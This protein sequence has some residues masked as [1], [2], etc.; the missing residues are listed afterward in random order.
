MRPH[1]TECPIGQCGKATG[2]KPYCPKHMDVKE[3]RSLS[4]SLRGLI[5]SDC[6]EAPCLAGKV[7]DNGEQYCTKCKEPCCWKTAISRT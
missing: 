1:T 4:A 7:H 5:R 2:G 3:R 6:C